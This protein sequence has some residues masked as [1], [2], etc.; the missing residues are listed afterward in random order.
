MQTLV[1][2]I[3]KTLSAVTAINLVFM[4]DVVFGL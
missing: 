4:S 2:L 1:F 3:I